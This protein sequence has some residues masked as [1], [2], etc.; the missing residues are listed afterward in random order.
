[1][2]NQNLTNIKQVQ[3]IGYKQTFPL[4]GWSKITVKDDLCTFD[5]SNLKDDSITF[6]KNRLYIEY[7]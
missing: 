2:N 7:K 5:Y 6:H 4:V 3:V 1:M